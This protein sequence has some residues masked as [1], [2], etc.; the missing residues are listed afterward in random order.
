MGVFLPLRM[1]VVDGAEGVPMYA[2]ETL[3]A[4]VDHGLVVEDGGSRRRAPGST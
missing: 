3:Q 1:K 2:R 4:M